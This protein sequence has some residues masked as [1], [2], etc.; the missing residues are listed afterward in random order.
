MDSARHALHYIAEVTF[1]VTPAVTPAFQTLRHTGTTLALSKGSMLSEELRA[2]RQ[3]Q[4]YRHGVRQTGGDLNTE[5]SYGTLDSLLEAVLCGTW[6]AKVAPYAAMTIS[7]AAADNSINDSANG[8]P[9]LDVGDKVTISGFT[10]TV[11]NNQSGV[12]LT[13]TAGKMTLTTVTPF[14]DDAAGE[15][16]TVTT[17]VQRLKAGVVR[18]SFSILRHFS[19]GA[20]G[21]KPYHLFVGQELNTLN[22]SIGVEA[23][24]TAGFGVIGKNQSDPSETAPAGA[25]FVAGNTNAVMDSFAGA[26]QEGGAAIATVTELTLTLEN[27][28]TPRPT[29][30]SDQV[31]IAAGIGRSNLTGQLTAYAED[32]SLIEKFITNNVESSIKVLLADAAGNKLRIGLP[33]IKY[34]GGQ[35]DTQGQGSITI[36]LPF[37]AL[38]DATLATNIYIDR[39]AV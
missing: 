21:S 1:G 19:D 32:E 2:D 12:V 29:V 8:L 26:L 15:E 20:A 31:Q 14:V 3:I 5:V 16:V 23:I 22:L 9:I 38:Y 4:D 36:P 34:T 11:G 33:R 6:A 7:A 25:T 24:V 27:G 10:G 17:N 13:S 18:R 39:I 37:Q 28:V 35:Q 30:G